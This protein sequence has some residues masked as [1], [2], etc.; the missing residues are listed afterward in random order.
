M[1]ANKWDFFGLFLLFPLE[2]KFTCTYTNTLANFTGK[3]AFLMHDDR[4]ALEDTNSPPK[5]M[6]K[7]A[8]W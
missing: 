5:N 4:K 7:A 6:L 8:I 2:F 1:H 3:G